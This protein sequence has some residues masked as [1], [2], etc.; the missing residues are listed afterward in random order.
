MNAV[1][2]GRAL[3]GAFCASLSLQ[4]YW[5]DLETGRMEER[6]RRLR[7]MEGAEGYFR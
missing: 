7:E 2:A 6:V 3:V 1:V 4:N 5:A